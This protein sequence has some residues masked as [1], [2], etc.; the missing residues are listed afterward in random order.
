MSYLCTDQD[1]LSLSNAILACIPTTTLTK[2]QK[3]IVL[4]IRNL[5][6]FLS[7]DSQ[8]IITVIQ[9][10]KQTMFENFNLIIVYTCSGITI[11]LRRESRIKVEG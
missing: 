7:S 6:R 5:K 10:T 11:S 9:K 8:K 4:T 2:D 1:L 3:P